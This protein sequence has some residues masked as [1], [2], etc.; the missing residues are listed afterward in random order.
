M[1]TLFA[2]L[3]AVV[4]E[5]AWALIMKVAPPAEKDVPLLVIPPRKFMF[6]EVVT[7]VEVKA[8][9]SETLP[10]NASIPKSFESV[11][12]PVPVVVPKMIRSLVF[13]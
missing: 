13:E 8:P 10:T 4:P 6:A 7:A 12:P 1:I 11:N 2:K 3:V 5:M 9:V